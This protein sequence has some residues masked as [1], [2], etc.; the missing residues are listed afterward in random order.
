MRQQHQRAV[1]SLTNH[2]NK[3]LQ[4]QLVRQRLTAKAWRRHQRYRRNWQQMKRHSQDQQ[5]V[6]ATSNV[7]ILLSQLLHRFNP[8]HNGKKAARRAKSSVAQRRCTMRLRRPSTRK[9]LTNRY[10]WVVSIVFFV[11]EKLCCNRISLINH[12]HKLKSDL[13]PTLLSSVQEYACLL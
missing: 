2:T 7:R 13:I 8:H 1:E 10:R 5:T 3:Q 9:L 11:I 4:L 6:R 12:A